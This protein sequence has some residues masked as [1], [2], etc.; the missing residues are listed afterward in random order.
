[1]VDAVDIPEKAPVMLVF[2]TLLEHVSDGS[3]VVICF[4]AIIMPVTECRAQNPPS[5][6]VS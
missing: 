1:M 2:L 5:G 6:L 4:I 3:A